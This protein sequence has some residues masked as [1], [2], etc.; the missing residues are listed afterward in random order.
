MCSG[1]SKK[2]RRLLLG[3][4]SGLVSIRSFV[5]DRGSSSISSRSILSSFAVLAG[6]IRQALETYA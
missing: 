3:V 4:L 1:R 6:E 5:G 2:V